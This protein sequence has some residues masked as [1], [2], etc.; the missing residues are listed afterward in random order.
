MT[1]NTH[2]IEHLEANR[3]AQSS[4]VTADRGLGRLR[5]GGDVANSTFLSGYPQNLAS[6]ISSQIRHPQPECPVG[7]LS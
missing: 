5:F 2:S 3:G 4:T 7:R 1:I 6:A